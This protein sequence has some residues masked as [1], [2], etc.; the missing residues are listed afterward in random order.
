[1]LIRLSQTI[2][3]QGSNNRSREELIREIDDLKRYEANYRAIV[4]GSLDAM[5]IVD[6][7]GAIMYVNPMAERLFEMS[8]PEM[9]GA[10]FG[11]PVALAEPVEMYVLQRFKKFVAVEMGV[12]PIQ[13]KGSPAYLVSLR[14]ITRVARAREE[15]RR[16]R[17]QL[18]QEV[19]CRTQDLAS[20]IVKLQV[21]TNAHKIAEEELKASEEKF[22]TL[23]E[24]THAG[25]VLFRGD[26][27]IY[28]NPM[29]EKSLGYSKD[30]LLAM[31][32]W[33][34]IHPDSREMVRRRGHA[35]QQGLPVPSRYE[36]KVLS[37]GGEVLWAEF[38]AGVIDYQGQPTVIATI[39][40][41]TERKRTEEA[42][43][44]SEEKFRVLAE[45]APV[46][47]CILQDGKFQ[48]VNNSTE[49]IAG[50]D[51]GCLLSTDFLNIV[52][53]DFRGHVARLYDDWLDGRIRKSRFEIKIMRRDGAERW[54]DISVSSI[55]YRGRPG[56]ILMATDVTDRKRA[57]W[58]SN[59]R[60]PA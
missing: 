28:V 42:L 38:S 13:W 52:H 12:V 6:L 18:E 22:R 54:V 7:D 55:D 36:V 1:L 56:L 5:L 21:E 37:K 17:D 43:R 8:G 9:M 26:K 46:A 30:E 10:V 32:F 2:I 11:F 39:F 41:I 14:N 31:N 29:T 53:P 23:A 25:I 34:I 48:Y 27:Y 19:R 47:I 3:R 45:T 50:Y 33:E 16:Y 49:T 35:R 4:E 51:R 58:D 24:T 20:T 44:E 15:L 40:D 57:R 60:Y 59:P